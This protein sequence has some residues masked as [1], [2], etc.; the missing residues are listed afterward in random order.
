VA[1]RSL[2]AVSG[3]AA[4]DGRI[5]AMML[6]SASV[7]SAAILLCANLQEPNSHERHENTKH[8][9]LFRAFRV[10]RVF[11]VLRTPAFKIRPRYRHPSDG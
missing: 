5:D 9:D 3:G 10:F 1:P 7:S 8:D 6:R 2:A 11:V 4:S